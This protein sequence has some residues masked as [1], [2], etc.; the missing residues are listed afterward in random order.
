[1]REPTGVHAD[2]ARPWRKYLMLGQLP[3]IPLSGVIARRLEIVVSS[4]T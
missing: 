1:M 2:A 3:K 4:T